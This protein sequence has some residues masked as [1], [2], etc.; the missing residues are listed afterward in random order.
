[1]SDLLLFLGGI[2]G[3]LIIGVIVVY[4][5]NLGKCKHSWGKWVYKE[6]EFAYVNQRGCEKCGFVET[7]QFRKMKE[8]L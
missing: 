8:G 1:M 5:E 7:N 4:V 3:M 2:V 6:D